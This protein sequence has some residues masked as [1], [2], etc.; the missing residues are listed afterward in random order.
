MNEEELRQDRDEW[1]QAAGDGLTVI[2]R[3]EKKINEL[4][5][6]LKKY[7][8]NPL[9]IVDTDTGEITQPLDVVKLEKEK[10]TLIEVIKRTKE[11]LLNNDEYDLHTQVENI[12]EE[13]DGVK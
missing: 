5:G 2:R 6:E 1:A 7:K 4:E 12:E 3:Q 10:D 9:F 13:E 11:M 8:E